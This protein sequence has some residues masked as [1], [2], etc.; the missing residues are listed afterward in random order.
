MRST[1][2]G[3]GNIITEGLVLYLDAANQASYPGSGTTW[4]DLTDNKNNGTLTNGPTFNSA[5]GGSIVFDGVDDY[6]LC[7][8]QTSLVST[9]QLTMCAW[10][11]RNLFN[12]RVIGVGQ[13]VGV[14]NDVI[15]ELW[16]DGFA[17][18]E[19][20]NGANSYGTVANT[21]TDWQY[22]VMTFDGT[23][24]GNANRL[25]GY[26]NGAL[27][28]LN[29]NTSIPSSTGTVDAPLI[30]GAGLITGAYSNGNISNIKIYNRALSASEVQ[31]NYNA[32]KYRFGL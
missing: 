6:V 15:F 28:T 16:D 11:K 31:Q 25:K 8:K 19:V 17:Y 9:T 27:Q 18:F 24:S 23:Q 29:Y 2:Q 1:A 20:G 14:G 32:L 4:F 13:S 3:P 30:I 12:S 10:M 22:L 21:S 26:V 5:N 7:S